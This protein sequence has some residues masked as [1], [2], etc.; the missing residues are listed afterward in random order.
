MKGTIEN[1]NSVAPSS[2]FEI[3]PN[4]FKGTIFDGTFFIENFCGHLLATFVGNF[5]W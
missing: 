3:D 2:S 4:D 5:S 1:E